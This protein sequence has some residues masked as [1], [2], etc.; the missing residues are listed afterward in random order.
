MRADFIVQTPGG[1]LVVEAKN[2]LHTSAEWARELRDRLA[3]SYGRE[4]ANSYA[5]VTPERLYFWGPGQAQP[6]I[7]EIRQALQKYVRGTDYD[8]SRLNGHSF[9]LIVSSLLDDLVRGIDIGEVPEEVRSTVLR[10]RLSV[11]LDRNEAIRGD[12]LPS[13]AGA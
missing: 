5:V 13:R 1:R 9:E 8:S 7:A 3:D 2:R 12:E 6:K 10:G 4:S 11:T